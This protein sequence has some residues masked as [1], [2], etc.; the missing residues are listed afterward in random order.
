MHVELRYAVRAV[1]CVIHVLVD[2]GIEFIVVGGLAATIHGAARLTLD[3]D[4]IYRR[5]PDNV[6][7]LA[8]TLEP[9]H[10][11]LRGAPPGLPFNLD[12]DTIERGLN[13]TLTTDLGRLDDRAA[14]ESSRSARLDYALDGLGCSRLVTPYARTAI[15]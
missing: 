3:L 15:V 11:Y 12:R 6:Q 2:A 5:T 14:A 1:D 13:F 7:R 9:Y 4:V 8:D 10:P